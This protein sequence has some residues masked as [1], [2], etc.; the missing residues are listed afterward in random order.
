M[1]SAATAM[2]AGKGL[3]ILVIHAVGCPPDEGLLRKLLDDAGLKAASI[4][5]ATPAEIA[6]GAINPKDFD[7][8]ITLLDDELA[9][10]DRLE[11]GMLGVAQ[12]GMGVTGIWTEGAHS[13]E[14]H[15]AL[16]K[17]GAKQIPW[18]AEQLSQA[19]SSEA[20][21]T[22]QSTSGESAAKHDTTHNKC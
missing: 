22:Y 15:P 2:P 18:N 8:V 19:L 6:S 3:K 11:A 17:F 21:E 20:P 12:C 9:E 13:E 1:N 5:L 4:K 16:Q 10:D 14:M 7:H